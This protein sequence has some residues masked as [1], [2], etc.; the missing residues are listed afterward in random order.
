MTEKK[1]VVGANPSDVLPFLNRYFARFGEAVSSIVVF[2]PDQDTGGQVAVGDELV[3]SRNETKPKFFL[4]WR[5]KVVGYEGSKPKYASEDLI[6]SDDEA[7]IAKFAAQ[8]W[9]KDHVS[10]VAAS[11]K[12]DLA[13]RKAAS[14]PATAETKAPAITA[15]VTTAAIA[16]PTTTAAVAAPAIV[17]KASEPEKPVVRV[18]VNTAFVE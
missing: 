15:P 10:S 8:Y 12:Q 17:G 6:E 18:P 2:T 1:V 14:A 4:L 3:I 7:V 5:F 13:A 16:A 9:F 11:I